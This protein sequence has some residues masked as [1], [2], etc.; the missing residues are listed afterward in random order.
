MA[1]VASESA[2]VIRS[3][4]VSGKMEMRKNLLLQHI[5]RNRSIGRLELGRDLQMSKSR[6][7]EVVQDMIDEGLILESLDGTERRGRRPVPLSLNPDHGC[8]VGLDFEAKRMRVVVVDFS[9]QTLFKRHR[10]LSPISDRNKLIDRLLGFIEEG[11]EAAR[12]I[13]TEIL[14]IG[15]AA[16]GII[17]RNTGTLVHY[18]FIEAARNIPLGELIQ[19]QAGLPCLVDN[20][21]RCYAMTEW[22][23]GAA[24]NMSD[25]ICFAVRNGFG[26]AIILNGQLLD[27]SHGYS[28][29]SGY[30]RVAS[31]KPISEWKTFQEVVSEKALDVDFE[32]KDFA[33]SKKKAQTAGELLGARAA[34]LATLLDPEAIILVGKLLEPDGPLWPFVEETYRNFIL[35]DIAELV[36]LLHSQ[37][38]SYA[39]ALGATQRCFQALFPINANSARKAGFANAV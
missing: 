37:V 19:N 29:E 26:S 15:V 33:L 14:G 4:T 2:M 6:L 31:A 30:T 13:G 25:F 28:G 34:S 35:P 24:R 36:P 10:T 3:D 32:A 38:D 21:I 39:A 5:H 1:I 9:G 23:S 27:G 20:N 18:D 17:N 11:L 22:T 8:F 12:R 7:C 16:P